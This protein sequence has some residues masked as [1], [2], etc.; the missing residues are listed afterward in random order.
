MESQRVW[1]DWATQQQDGLQ[2]GSLEAEL[3]QG[4]NDRWLVEGERT[5]GERKDR[6]RE[7]IEAFR[8][9]WASADPRG[10]PESEW[11]ARA[12]LPE[13][14]SGPYVISQRWVAPGS[15]GS[16]YN[17]LG[18]WAG[19]FWLVQAILCQRG[20]VWVTGSQQCHSWGGACP[21]REQRHQG[22]CHVDLVV[23]SLSVVR[24]CNPIDC[25]T[26]GSLVLHYLPEFALRNSC[27]LCW[28]CHLTQIKC[29]LSSSLLPVGHIMSQSNSLMHP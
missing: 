22:I 16:G 3:R 11:P 7:V 6:A 15:E 9:D 10:V 13:E 5:T 2:L 28:C 24:L 23:K 18:F 12:V 27:P 20:Q 1:H 29:S 17:L 21:P 19:G 8:E 4:L 25:S 14:S 26:P